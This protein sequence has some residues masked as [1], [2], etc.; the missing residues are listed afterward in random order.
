M[1]SPP[2]IIGIIRNQIAWS[3]SGLPADPLA[4]RATLSQWV[5]EDTPTAAAARARPQPR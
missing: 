2:V 1:L 5:A 4:A 3:L